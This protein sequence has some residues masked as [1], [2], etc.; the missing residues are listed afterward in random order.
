VHVSELES[1]E[2]LRAAAD[3]VARVWERPATEVPVPVDLLRTLTHSGNYVAGAYLDER[4]V[5]VSV[6]LFGLSGGALHLHS[7]VT[8]V[9][10]EAQDRDV[11]FALKQH[12]RAWALERGIPT[13]GWTF[14]PLIRRNGFFNLTKLGAEVVAYRPH[15]YG[16]MQDAFNLGDE[17]DRAV[18]RWELNSKRAQRAAGGNYEEPDVDALLEAGAAVVL[19]DG[20]AVGAAHGDV[21]LAWVPEDIVGLRRSDPTHALRWRRAGRESFGQAIH[22]GYVATAMARSGW[23]VLRRPG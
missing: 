17:T 23:Y 3:L 21:L 6:G 11:G 20:P 18:V 4:L 10:R 2:Q 19:D 7:F 9:L 12:Q 16:E 5:G 14:D 22:D 8:G 15:F 13:I 1:L